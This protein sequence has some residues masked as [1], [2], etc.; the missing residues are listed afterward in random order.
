MWAA[1]YVEGLYTRSTPTEDDMYAPSTADTRAQAGQIPLSES[2]R[3]I[4][5]ENGRRDVRANVFL[6]AMVGLGALTV[7]TAVVF[8]GSSQRVDTAPDAS[9]ASVAAAT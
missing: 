7:L 6:A 8:G 9:T 3:L 5:I 2:E 1:D 4:E